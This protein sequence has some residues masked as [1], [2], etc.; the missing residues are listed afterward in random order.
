MSHQQERAI[1]ARVRHG[2]ATPGRV[3]PQGRAGERMP[4][5]AGVPRERRSLPSVGGAPRA[6]RPGGGVIAA[7][8]LG[9]LLLGYGV[10]TLVGGEPGWGVVAGASVGALLAALA[11]V[12]RRS[13]GLVAPLP[14][15][16]VAV[17]TAGAVLTSHG[18]PATRLVRW[19]VAVFPAMAAAECAVVVVALAAAVLR[20]KMRR[21]DRA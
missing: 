8:L 11:A 10:D 13:L 15:L 9:P 5:A 16:A 1:G 2:S 19:A 20:S 18:P 4:S 14:V 21:R 12:R 6:G 3:V 7:M 17:V